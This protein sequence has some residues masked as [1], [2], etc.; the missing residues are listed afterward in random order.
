MLQ[1]ADG[2]RVRQGDCH[3]LL[4][5]RPL[6]DPLV[7]YCGV[8]VISLV[9]QNQIGCRGS[10]RGILGD[11]LGSTDLN[12]EGVV[13]HRAR[14]AQGLDVD[15]LPGYGSTCVYIYEFVGVDGHRPSCT[16]VR[17][18][19]SISSDQRECYGAICSRSRKP[20]RHLV[21]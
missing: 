16:I 1:G 4:E 13:S 12:K 9:L 7:D 5:L 15:L 19:R 18:R 11:G 2:E 21:R 6:Q 17:E 20:S 8:H 10:R 3:E 14:R